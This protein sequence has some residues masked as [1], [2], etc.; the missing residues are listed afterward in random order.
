MGQLITRSQKI[1]KLPQ[2]DMLVTSRNNDRKIMQP[3]RIK[4]EISMKIRN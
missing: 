3:I 2:I 1:K 4:S